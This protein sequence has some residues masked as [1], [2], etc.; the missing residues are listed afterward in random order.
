M[1][2]IKAYENINGDEIIVG[3]IRYS[4]DK[5]ELIPLTEMGVDYV[6]RQGDTKT[7]YYKLDYNAK[8]YFGF[9]G[10]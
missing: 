8:N 3:I 6:L 2:Y 10:K 5:N 1:R 7:A 4:D 9:N